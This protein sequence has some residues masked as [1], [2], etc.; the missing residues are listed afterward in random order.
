MMRIIVQIA[1]LLGT[2]T[3]VA[4]GDLHRYEE[5]PLPV[6]QDAR[7]P[8]LH[9]D[10]DGR[11]LMS[12]TEANKSSFAV[13][14]AVL[15]NGTW[16]EPRTVVT[17]PEL[18]VNWADSP[19]VAAFGDGTLI[20]HWLQKS[21]HSSYAY[22][23]KIVLSRDD[24]VTW[25][26]PVVPHGDGTKTQH[27]FVTLVPFAGEVVAVW[28]DG[29]AYD[30]A[31]M[32]AGA[33]EGQMQLRSAV[34]KPDGTLTSDVAIDFTTCS[35][36][37]TSA[38]VAGDALLVA[39]RDRSNEEIRDISVT[40]FRDGR[41]LAPVQVN[42]DNWE[43]SG[44]P[45]NGP[46]IDAISDQVVVA[47]FTGADDVPAVKVVFSGDAG[48]SFSEALRID[49]GEPI[50]RVDA[51]LLY[52]GTALISWVEWQGTDEVLL[53]CHVTPDGCGSTNQL[54][55][56]SE[57]NSINFPQMASTPEGFYVA[58]TQPL[59]NGHD[60]IRMMKSPR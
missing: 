11:L 20:A 16:S 54:T 8:S 6:G 3:S 51:L 46:A 47:W 48:A 1:L 22:D 33:I 56:N 25:S 57:R 35:C 12:W 41:W 32:E 23:V 42:H 31:L 38:A 59:P 40:A 29:R 7:E 13:K 28:L 49:N 14:I 24:G 30:G 39:Y 15:E 26:P 36:C 43:I 18:F 50:G 53:V 52:D 45:V 37:Q 9:T 10:P 27:G 2:V 34:I 55:V 21:G 4:A 5:F 19:S 44:C 58:W 60:T 17:S